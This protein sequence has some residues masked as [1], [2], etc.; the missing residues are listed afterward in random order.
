MGHALGKNSLLSG[1]LAVRLFVYKQ[2]KI[3]I[4]YIVSGLIIWVISS[5]V[6][7]G[8]NVS[9]GLLPVSINDLDR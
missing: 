4:E 2:V 7:Q 1:R 8:L 6:V 9:E 5:V 3:L